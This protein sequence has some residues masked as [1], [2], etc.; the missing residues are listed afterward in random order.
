M[1]SESTIGAVRGRSRRRRRGL[2][3]VGAF[4]LVAVLALV[5][6]ACELRTEAAKSGVLIGAGATNPGYLD[7][8]QFATVLGQ[9]FNSLSPENELKWSFNEPQQGVFDFTKLDRIV[10]YAQAHHMAVKGHGL[11]SGCCNPDWLQQITDPAALR[12]AMTNHFETLMTRYAGKVDRWDVV[13]EA[14]SIAGGTGLDQNYFYRVLGP[15]YIAD[16]FEI[17]HAADP[18]AKLF[19]NESLVEAIPTK[20]QELYD[21]VSGLVKSGV[22][23]D[24]VGLEMHIFGRPQRGVIADM[25]T[26]Y[27]A[28]GLEVA[29][30]EMDVQLRTNVANPLQ[31][32]ADTYAQVVNEA[33]HAGIRDIS[34]WGFTDKYQAWGPGAKPLLFDENYKAK[35]AFLAV[36]G[37][38]HGFGI[39]PSTR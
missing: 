36:W 10:D 21:L 29:I 20:R 27:R 1:E 37:A 30:T 2:R 9:Q 3:H 17:A 5:A 24:G 19:L 28:L 6:S 31:D 18:N 16:A 22:P 32:Q 39:E 13:T 15:D 26:A 14:L 7:D 8:P 35:P 23:I 33:L 4:A 34:F 11:I 38:L 12:A 25:V